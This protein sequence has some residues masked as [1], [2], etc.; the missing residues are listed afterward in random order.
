MVNEEKGSIYRT[1]TLSLETAIDVLEHHFGSPIDTS[2]NVTRT[3]QLDVGRVGQN[4]Y[5]ARDEEF[6]PD[7]LDPGVRRL[8]ADLDWE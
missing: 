7:S 3:R 1:S 5:V 8:P 6:S 2:E 4:S